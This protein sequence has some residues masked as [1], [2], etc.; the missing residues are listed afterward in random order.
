MSKQISAIE[1]LKAL[2]AVF[3]GPDLTIRFEWTSKT[4]SHYLYLW[5]KRGLVQALGGHS[6][7]FAN[8]LRSEYADWEQ[9]LLMVH[10]S[11]LVMGLESLRQYGWTTQIPFLP[12]VAVEDLERSFSI[13]HFDI[14]RKSAA[15]MKFAR[16]GIDRASMITTT[17]L[18]RLRPA[19]ALADLISSQGWGACGL[20]PDDLDWD[21]ITPQDEKDWADASRTWTL[22]FPSLL[23]MAEMAQ[24]S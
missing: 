5:K 23:S 12:T 11:A 19:W 17:A 15:W 6:D 21:A 14:Q 24:G 1:R 20:Q 13:D 3:R 4:A 7:V 22:P 9:A 8:L 2:P 16:Q 10:P 18:P